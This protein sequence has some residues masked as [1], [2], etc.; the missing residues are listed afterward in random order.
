MNG[1]QRFCL[2]RVWKPF[3]RERSRDQ[4]EI[5]GSPLGCI[6]FYVFTCITAVL[7]HTVGPFSDMFGQTL[8]YMFP[9]NISTTKLNIVIV[10]YLQ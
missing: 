3:E 9:V 5:N 4:M 1:M 2:V 10:T 7:N 8:A 6:K